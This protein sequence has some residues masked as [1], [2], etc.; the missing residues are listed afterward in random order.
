MTSQRSGTSRADRWSTS[1]NGAGTHLLSDHDAERLVIGQ[2][3][4]SGDAF[5]FAFDRLEEASFVTTTYR[6]LWRTMATLWM[7]EVHISPEG[8]AFRMGKDIDWLKAAP[9]APW[10][11]FEMAVDTV[12][13]LWRRN[14]LAFLGQEL[15]HRALDLT[16]N[17]G[18]MVLDIAERLERPEL[19]V[20]TTKPS[21]TLAE[22]LALDF[23]SNWLVPGLLER[24]DRLI[25]TG[26]EGG[27]KSVFLRQWALC[28]A[29]G[30]DPV[31][32]ARIE[33]VRVLYI[34]CENS[35]RQNQRVIN[36]ML[37]RVS[38][39][40]PSTFMIETKQYGLDL[41]HGGDQRWLTSC[42]AANA[43]DVIIGG[44]LYKMFTAAPEDEASA[45]HIAMYFDR[46]RT[47]FN[48]ALVFE[49]HSPHGFA[50]DRAG[51]RPFGSSLWL[52]WP[53]FGFG[54]AVED[55]KH[56]EKV[57]CVHWRG[58]RDAD[59]HFPQRLER[60]PLDSSAWPWR[61]TL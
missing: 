8:V 48:V 3:L 1:L 53:E 7:E 37:Q 22:F 28:M 18:A 2:C 49:A 20:E 32:L 35:P 19:S 26:P 46:L 10:S 43:P 30:Y 33:P 39:S 27:G 50:G 40:P 42:V 16:E 36:R 11:T 17:E 55:K 47:R 51:L 21:P 25:V 12:L 45:R 24:T 34:D 58:P 41:L 4:R 59:R 60:T 29:L 61:A 5:E 52:R 13:T 44:P 38:A 56:P 57:R 31:N 23:P 54:M 9:M 15:M 14:R 6:E